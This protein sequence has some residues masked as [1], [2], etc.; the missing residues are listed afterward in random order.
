MFLVGRIV[1]PQ[2]CPN[3]KTL[4]Y[5]YIALLGKRD[6]EKVTKVRD[7]KMVRLSSWT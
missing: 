5:E 6:F 2:I 7:I 4:S 1:D 3:L